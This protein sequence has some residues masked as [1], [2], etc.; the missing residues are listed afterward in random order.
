ME[1][2]AKTR[3]RDA[4][5][6]LREIA[7][8]LDIPH[9]RRKAD[10][11]AQVFEALHVDFPLSRS[12][13]VCRGGLRTTL[14]NPLPPPAAQ[15]APRPPSFLYFYNPKRGEVL[16]DARTPFLTCTRMHAPH[17]LRA[18]GCTRPIFNVHAD[19]RGPFFTC[20]RMHA[21]HF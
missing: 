5:G 14:V 16:A 20:T 10:F 11:S 13:P 7:F 18:R 8:E 21:P 15:Q 3:K 6:R 17:F 2:C 19:A 12:N 1:P 4:L 9:D